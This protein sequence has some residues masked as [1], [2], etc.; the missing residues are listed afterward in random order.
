MIRDDSSDTEGTSENDKDLF[1]RKGG[2]ESLLLKKQSGDRQFSKE[3]LQ[4][5]VAK[6]REMFLVQYALGI[7]KQEMKKLEEIVQVSITRS[8]FISN[9]FVLG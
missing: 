5:F 6:K 8:Y 3:T 2:K 1:R 7:K 4:E 9:M